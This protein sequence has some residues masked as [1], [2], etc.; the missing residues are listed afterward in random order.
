MFNVYINYAHTVATTVVGV[1]CLYVGP[2]DD[3]QYA[4]AVEEKLQQHGQ[5]E[6]CLQFAHQSP[7]SA[8]QLFILP[9]GKAEHIK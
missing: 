1:D 5:R 4:D 2:I 7:D 6:V 3:M 8:Q 9:Q